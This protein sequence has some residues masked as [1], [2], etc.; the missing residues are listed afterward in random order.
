MEKEDKIKVGVIGLG[1]IANAIY[2]PILS[3]L[4]K[5]EISAVM[6]RTESTMRKI[7][8][9]FG[10][11]RVCF[12]LKEF[13]E[14]HLDC[15]FILTPKDVHTRYVIPLLEEGTDVFCEKPMAMSLEE[16][17]RMVKVADETRRI[18]MIGFNRRYAPVYTYAKEVF[19]EKSPDVCF[20]E[21]NR[22]DTEYRA[23][24]ENAIHMVDLMRWYCGECK[25][26][27]AYSQFEDP[28]Y[29]TN[30]T[31]QLRFSNGSIG[32]LLASRTAGQWMERAE[33]YGGN[34]TV[35]VECPERV[36]V[37][38][39]Q[40]EV[41]I[42]TT[43]LAMGW[44]DVKENLGFRKQ[45]QS[46]LECVKTRN[47]PPTCAAEALKTHILMDKILRQASLPGL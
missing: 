15:A 21:K 35:I 22:P 37:Y 31:A 44:A 33:I 40:N 9:K 8:A 28:Y 39:P 47:Q 34:K 4:E 13:V 2:L 46:F 20:L 27:W 5:V 3:G 45:V 17:S 43:P 25:E 14:T 23:S 10:A 7:A 30:L 26:V 32:L 11:K 41:C 16:A 12:S 18:L 38:N 42:S 29:E 36:R 19:K 6:C 24:F 1:T